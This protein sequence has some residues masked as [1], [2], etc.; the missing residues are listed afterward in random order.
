MLDI[1]IIKYAEKFNVDHVEVRYQYLERD[2]IILRDE[3]LIDFVHGVDEGVSIRVLIDGC[4]GFA[5]TCN[6][7][8]D[9]IEETI[10]RAIKLSRVQGGR[11][12][13]KL[14]EAD[15]AKGSFQFNFKIDPRN[16]DLK[17]K[18]SILVKGVENAREIA[19]E[20]LK[21]IE[22]N[23][24]D[25]FFKTQ[26]LSSDG[27]DAIQSGVRFYFSFGVYGETQNGLFYDSERYGAISG[28]EKLEESIIDVSSRM[29]K[30]VLNQSKAQKPPTGPIKAILESRAAG[31]F[32]HEMGHSFEADSVIRR[33]SAFE[34]LKNQKIAVENLTVYE[35]PTIPNAWGSIFFDDEG[36]KPRR[37]ILIENGVL[38]GYIHSR[39]TAYRL[40][41]APTGHARAESF[42]YE[43]IVRMGNL[44]VKSGDW[45]EEELIRETREGIYIAGARGGQT[46]GKGPFQFQASEAFII[47]NGELTTPLRSIGVSMNILEALKGIE[48]ICD[49]AQYYITL[50][51]KGDQRMSV[52]AYAPTIKIDKVIIGG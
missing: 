2:A 24:F 14:A 9:K 46:T 34:G 15:I 43:P 50:C 52:T 41:E 26:F 45:S 49:K 30:R 17:D 5:Y 38:K 18:L 20:N 32:F 16:I 21:S 51:G 44:I 31:D 1:N 27:G 36:V 12:I 11:G 13:V 29:A 4:W 35:D 47:K 3:N 22:I 19:K 33:T 7:T 10:R 40:N 6:P 39:E 25:L 8:K 37:I 48:A 42:M 28:L 23:Y